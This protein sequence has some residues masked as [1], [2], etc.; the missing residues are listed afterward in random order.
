MN[1]TRTVYYGLISAISLGCGATTA[2]DDGTAGQESSGGISASADGDAGD[3]TAASVTASASA[4]GTGAA[5]DDDDGGESGPPPVKLDVH[6]IPDVP[7]AGPCD[8]GS[9]GKGGGGADPD[10]SYIWVSNS[11]Q[12]TVS[13]INTVSMIEEGRYMTRENSSGDP[14]RTSV[15]LN[16][17]VA[18]ANRN[19]GIVKIH[20]RVEDCDDPGNTSEGANDIKAFPDGCVAWYTPFNYASQRPVAWAPGVWSDITCR[21]ENEKLWTSGANASIDVILLDGDSG[22]V[23]QTIPIPGVQ[24]S[25]Y[26]IYGGAVDADGNFWGTMLGGP[27]MIHVDR[28]SFDHI[29]YPMANIGGY[30]MTVDEEGRPWSCSS[31]IARF[32]PINETWDVNPNVGGGGGCM[33]DGNGHVWVG[34][35][36][37]GFA[38]GK[39][40]GV[41]VETL[42]VVYNIDIPNYVHGVSVDFYGYVWGVTL[43]QPDAYRVDIEAGTFETFT[44]LTGPYTYSDMTGWALSNATGFPPSG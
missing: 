15:S 1:T 42:D 8:D 44:G 43:M 27:S 38:G 31:G 32:D 17:D 4:E 34:G 39:M 9:G 5:D 30:G 10:F 16:G 13:K 28:S 2:K 40:I 22:E 6:A 20:A 19:G 21:Y 23:E 11:G 3:P 18:V 36:G 24:P 26:G 25:F 33:S 7:P 35:Y 41:D 29:V 14:S 37:G 12:S